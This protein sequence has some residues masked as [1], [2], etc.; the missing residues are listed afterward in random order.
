[1]YNPK[2]D[3]FDLYG[4]FRECEEKGS[5][6]MTLDL[7]VRVFGIEEGAGKLADKLNCSVIESLPQ[8]RNRFS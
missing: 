6:A 8:L 2:E 4:T 3:N 7:Y 5:I 1:M